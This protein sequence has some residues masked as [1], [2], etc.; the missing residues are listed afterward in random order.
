MIHQ[1]CIEAIDMTKFVNERGGTG[2]AL[3]KCNGNTIGPT[4]AN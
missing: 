4:T 3:E 1:K 2:K